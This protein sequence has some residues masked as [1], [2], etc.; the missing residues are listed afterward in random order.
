MVHKSFFEHRWADYKED[1]L[2]LRQFLQNLNEDNYLPFK[3]YFGS[4][5]P[6]IEGN[7]FNPDNLTYVELYSN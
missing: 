6:K 1:F 5:V 3:K 2:A 4:T 7:S